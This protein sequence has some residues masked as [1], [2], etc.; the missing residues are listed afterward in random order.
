MSD[1]EDDNHYAKSEFDS[2]EDLEQVFSEEMKDSLEEDIENYDDG[3]GFH[4]S[5]DDDSDESEKEPKQKIVTQLP[6]GVV[7]EGLM[8]TCIL[9]KDRGGGT[10]K[11]Y[12]NSNCVD[13]N[14][15]ENKPRQPRIRV[16]RTKKAEFPIKPGN[17]N[18][19]DNISTIKTILNKNH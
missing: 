14:V 9:S 1:Y 15:K 10:I 18:P 7:I 3:F 13:V 6:K 5:G 8:T 16:I 19:V 2:E 12:Y 4:S 17:S 11:H